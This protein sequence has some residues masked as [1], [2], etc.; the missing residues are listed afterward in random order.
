MGK[1]QKFG[2]VQF[3][4]GAK[5]GRYPYCNSLYIEHAGI[6]IDPSSDRKMLKELA[7]NI[8]SIWLSH[9]HEDHIMHLDLFGHAKLCAHVKDAPPLADIDEFI[10]WYGINGQNKPEIAEGW[11]TMMAELFHFQPRKIDENLEGGQK[12]DIVNEVIEILH[13][14]GHSPG[15]LSFYFEE[16]GILFLGDYDLTAFGPWYG[17]RYSDIDQI[18]ES[19]NRLRKIPAKIWLAGHEDGVFESD[20]GDLWDQYLN[21]I[22]T[23]DEKLLSLLKDPKTIEEIADA[24]IIYGK[25]IKPIAEFHFIEQLSMKKHLD[26]LIS[27]GTV[28]QEAEFYRLK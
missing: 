9:W 27:K 22:D 23:R 6:V 18:I 16:S 26:R 24:W 8:K 5:G 3:I 13:T 20:P 14:P 17:D 15:N 19:V 4:R 2:P 12:I 25:P 28:Q 10:N 11:K 7:G 21:V 1:I